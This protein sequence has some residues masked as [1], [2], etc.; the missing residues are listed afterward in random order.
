MNIW[1]ILV[2]ALTA[3]AVIL[4]VRSRLRAKKN[5]TGCCPGCCGDCGAGAEGCAGAPGNNGQ[6]G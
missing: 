4:A 5:G 6:G 2:L 1:D 3:A